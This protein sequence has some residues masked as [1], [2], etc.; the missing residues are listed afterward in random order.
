MLLANAYRAGAS[1]DAV[2][3]ILQD[4]VG[5]LQILQ[6]Q[7]KLYT[8][9]LTENERRDYDEEVQR[10]QRPIPIDRWI[11]RR[12]R[13]S[14]KLAIVQ[15]AYRAELLPLS[16]RD[17]LL[18]E[19]GEELPIDWEIRHAVSQG[20]LVL[21]DVPRTVFW[22]SL[23]VQADWS[24][25]PKAWDVMFQLATKARRNADLLERDVYPDDAVADATLATA[26]SRLKRML[27]C[28]LAERIEPGIQPRSQRL[29]LDPNEICI[30]R[31]ERHRRN[32][33]G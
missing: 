25:R 8:Q 33:S 13:I 28:T 22:D 32:D 30:F 16:N 18:R 15:L 3:P 31:N 21:V 20:G 5:R 6:V 27:P 1:A 2:M 10:W 19:L 14:H 7:D 24:K 4:L 12:R 29:K 11:T 26:V 17:W 23:T 9:F